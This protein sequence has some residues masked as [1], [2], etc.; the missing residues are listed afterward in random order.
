MIYNATCLSQAQDVDD[1]RMILIVILGSSVSLLGV[2]LNT[3]LLLSFSRLPVF[4]SNLLY[5]FLLA[6][7]DILVEICFVLIFVC[8]LL[9]DFYQIYPLYVIWHYYIRIVSTAGQVLIASSTLLIVAAS[10]ERYFCSLK[11]CLGFSDRQRVLAVIVV[12]LSALIMKGTVF[13]EL[14]LEYHPECPPFADLQLAQSSITKIDSYRLIWMFWGRSI[15]TVIV[16]FKL[17]LFLNAATISNLNKTS[18]DFESVLVEQMPSLLRANNEASSARRRKRDATRT[19]TAIV[20]IYLITNFINIIITIFEFVDSGL[21]EIGG[22][23]A[24]RYLSDLSSLLTISSTAV[25]LPVY[26]HCN[27]DMREQIRQNA[28]ACFTKEPLKDVGEAI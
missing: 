2:V 10:F 27:Q 7:C 21:L 5:L 19:L 20:S 15:L 1:L 14:E 8:S 24:Y 18:R 28:R 16:P 17:L 26:F 25:R 12:F 11:G 9:W 23:W 22:G 13:V 4:H 6:I 3:F